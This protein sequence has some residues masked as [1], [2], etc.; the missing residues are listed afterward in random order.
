MTELLQHW[1]LGQ[2]RNI[3]RRRGL[4][5]RRTPRRTIRLVPNAMGLEHSINLDVSY[6]GDPLPVHEILLEP[7]KPA[8]V[9]HPWPRDALIPGAPP[10]PTREMLLSVARSLNPRHISPANTSPTILD[11]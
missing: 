2:P 5:A 7:P 9:V 10:L 11:E 1:R 8:E 4:N 6:F 3:F